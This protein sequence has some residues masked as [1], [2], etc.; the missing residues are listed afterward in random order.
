MSRIRISRY[1]I[2]L[3]LLAILVVT[4][5]K[6]IYQ[7]SYV[8]L[9]DENPMIRDDFRRME[10]DANIVS[11]LYDA[12]DA[13]YEVA[14]HLLN[15]NFTKVD[16]NVWRNG[17]CWQEYLASCQ[18]VWNDLQCFPMEKECI[19]YENSWMYERTYGGK[20]GH[21]GCDLMTKENKA[22]IYPIY[23]ITDGIVTNKGWLEKGGYRIGILS[24][25]GGYFY[26]AH[27]ASYENLKEGDEIHAGQLLGYAGDTG[28]GPEGT[29]G[30]FPVHLHLGIYIYINEKEISV[31]PYSVLKYLENK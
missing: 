5:T 8:E 22:N 24:P 19:S 21:E 10:L 16:K 4:G 25:S 14:L 27:L 18:A 15:E 11:S 30:V 1:F 12:H 20:R 2:L 6:R 9:L 23:S 28:Y 31:N 17:R 29:T 7:Q 3:L 13:G 26:Y